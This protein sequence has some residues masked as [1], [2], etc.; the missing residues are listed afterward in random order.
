MQSIAPR[1]Y[2]PSPESVKKFIFKWTPRAIAAG[3]G[4]Y[5]A[6]GLAYEFGLMAVIDRLAI[7]ILK[8]AVGYAGIGALMPTFQWY[9][10]WGVRITAAS[11]TG[12][13]YDGVERLAFWC[14]RR[15]QYRPVPAQGLIQN[16]EIVI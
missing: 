12:L 10:A 15:V 6:L 8:Q 3:I 9:S 5:Y 16:N 1:S 14:Y 2:F 11:M 13:F 7:R 4:G